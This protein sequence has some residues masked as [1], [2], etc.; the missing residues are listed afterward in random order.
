M[1]V[2]AECRAAVQFNGSVKVLLVWQHSP[3]H[4]EEYCW[5]NVLKE[6]EAFSGGKTY[7]ITIEEGITP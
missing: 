3:N 5:L 6:R 2:K 1:Q 4:P 7:R